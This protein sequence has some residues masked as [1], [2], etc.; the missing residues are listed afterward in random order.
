M[1]VLQNRVAIVTGAMHV[2]GMGYATCRKFAEAGARVVITDLA[3]DAAAMD[4]LNARAAEITEAGGEAIAVA[5]DITD[6]E[7][8]AEC[9]ALVE[10]TY[11]RIDILFN[12]AGSPIGVGDFLTMTDEQWDV[13]Y[14][15]NLKGI[16]NFSQAALPAMIAQGG[17]VIVNNASVAGLGAVPKMAAYT[18]TKFA[19]VG[20][21]K[22][23]AA[24]F[25]PRGV[26][27]NA[28]CPG[29]VWTQMGQIEVEHAQQ[30]GETLEETR[31][32]LAS[33][34]LVPLDRKSVV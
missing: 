24:E 3:R 31:R 16:V 12:N 27:V 10:E 14:Q 30:A 4:Q 29:M 19:V 15:V 22:A 25:G 1:T 20:L 21:T 5:V 17:G 33:A 6:R 11:G 13:S 26:R 2:Q 32:R 9:A 7:Q 28:V 8:V 34:E 23:L 18:A